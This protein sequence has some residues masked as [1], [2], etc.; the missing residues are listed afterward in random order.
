M[1]P[2]IVGELFPYA[3]SSS[4]SRLCTILGL[5]ATTCGAL[6]MRTCASVSGTQPRPA[7]SRGAF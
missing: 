3:L 6:T 2:L 7:S 5:S 4:G 1:K